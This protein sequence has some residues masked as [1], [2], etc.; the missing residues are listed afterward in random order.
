MA[1]GSVEDARE[2]LAPLADE[3]PD[4]VFELLGGTW[5]EPHDVPP[6]WPRN[7]QPSVFIGP[8]VPDIPVSIIS[9]QGSS[10][11]S[12]APPFFLPSFEAV[13]VVAQPASAIAKTIIRAIIHRGIVVGLIFDLLFLVRVTSA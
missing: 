1:R 8:N 2:G 4:W 9:M 3:L 12:S 6:A 7:Q 5:S 10:G 11:G 13:L